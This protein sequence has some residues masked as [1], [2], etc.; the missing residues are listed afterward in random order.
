MSMMQRR[1]KINKMITSMNCSKTEKLSKE[2]IEIELKS[3]TSYNEKRLH[4]ENL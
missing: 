3:L 2:L 4:Y 1:T